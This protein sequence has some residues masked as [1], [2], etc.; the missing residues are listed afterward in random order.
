MPQAAARAFSQSDLPPSVEK[1]YYKKC[2]DLRRRITD[3]EDSNDGTRVRIRRLHRGIQ[4]MR[5]ERAFLLEQLQKHMEFSID[6]SDRSSSPP[7]T[8]TDKPLRSKRSHRK[9]T[10]PAGSQTGG[11][12]SVQQESPSNS[13][14]QPLLHAMNPMSSAQSTPDPSRSNNPFFSNIGATATSPHA[15]NGN[16]ESSLP[17]LQ[18]LRAPESTR[19]AYFDPVNDGARPPPGETGPEYAGRRRTL[20][21]TNPPVSEPREVQNGDIEMTDAAGSGFTSV[22]R[23]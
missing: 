19:G 4:K 1:A 18:S 8:P 11:A 17:P 7:P 14:H 9:G 12:A 15:V 22:N 23:G 5:L 16:A 3:I 2:I 6:D 10:P 13:H 21:G 20:S